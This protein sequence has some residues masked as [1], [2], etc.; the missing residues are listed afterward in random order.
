MPTHP[1]TWKIQLGKV[2]F[3]QSVYFVGVLLY[4]AFNWTDKTSMMFLELFWNLCMDKLFSLKKKVTSNILKTGLT[5]SVEPIGP[6][7]GE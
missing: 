6:G 3:E 7:T 5:Q 2:K 1:L 4:K